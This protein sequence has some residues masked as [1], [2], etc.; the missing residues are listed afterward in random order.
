MNHNTKQ[1]T[2]TKHRQGT[3]TASMTPG[4]ETKGSDIYNKG[5]QG[6]DGIQ[7]SLMTRRCA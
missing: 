6:S 2:R 4:K 7:V 3:E 1:E 5:N